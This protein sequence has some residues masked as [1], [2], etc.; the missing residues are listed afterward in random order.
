[1]ARQ[2]RAGWEGS[3]TRE[4]DGAVVVGI[5]LVDHVLELRL[6]GVLAERAHYGAELLGGDLTCSAAM[7]VVVVRGA[8]GRVRQGRGEGRG[9]SAA[10]R[11]T[12]KGTRQQQYWPGVVLPA[13]STMASCAACADA[14]RTV[15]ILVLGMACQHTNTETAPRG[16]AGARQPPSQAGMHLRTGKRLP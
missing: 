10:A 15:A 14:V 16:R 4:V 5:D 9:G 11:S 13:A 2:Q 7:S 1:M 6:A 3:R 8:D 12:G